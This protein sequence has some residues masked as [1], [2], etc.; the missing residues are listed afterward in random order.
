MKNQYGITMNYGIGELMDK[1]VTTDNRVLSAVSIFRMISNAITVA[2]A[3]SENNVT[4]LTGGAESRYD[5]TQNDGIKTDYKPVQK[6]I[7]KK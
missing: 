7:L 1:R 3:Q 5:S 2:K 4:V 6:I